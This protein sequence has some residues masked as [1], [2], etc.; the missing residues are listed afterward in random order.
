M[1][2]NYVA[3]ESSNVAFNAL[4]F[5]KLSITDLQSRLLVLHLV[6][7]QFPQDVPTN[8]IEC[9]DQQ[10]RPHLFLPLAAAVTAVELPEET[11]ATRAA[12]SVAPTSAPSAS[13]QR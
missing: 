12:S 2:G 1:A 3:G 13:G 7:N 10:S 11:A 4:K 9:E 6:H 8:Q 5:I